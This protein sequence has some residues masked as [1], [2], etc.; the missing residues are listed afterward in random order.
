MTIEKIS[1]RIVAEIAEIKKERK[2]IKPSH[3]N[4]TLRGHLTTRQHTLNEILV[5]MR[6]RKSL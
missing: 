4:E 5:L 6:S 3:L 1:Q 2:K